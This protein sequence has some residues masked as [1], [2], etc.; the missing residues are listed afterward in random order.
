[1]VKKVKR[2]INVVI[3][4]GIVMFLVPACH[5][6][7]PYN[8]APDSVIPKPLELEKRDGSFH[9]ERKATLTYD[10]CFTD[11]GESIELFNEFLKCDYR[12]YSI[13]PVTGASGPA[14]IT[15]CF[16]GQCKDEGY[17]LEIGHDD[18]KIEASDGRGVF[19]A[20]QSLM[21]LI[22]PYCTSRHGSISIPC[23]KITDAPEFKWRGLHFDVA[24]HFFDKE[25]IFKLLDAMAIHKLNTF[26][27]HLTDDQGWRIEIK[28]Y[29]ALTATGSWRS[30]TLVGHGSETPW[31]YDG[32]SAGG[33][34]TQDDIREIVEYARRLKINIVPEIEMP[35]HAVAALRSYPEYSCNGKRVEEFDRWGV[36][37]DLFC[38]GN[39][40]TYR[41]LTDIL[42]E[43]IDLFPYE[44]IHI[45]GD[46]CPKVNWENCPLCQ[47]KIAD[48]NLKD[49]NELH[50]YFVKRI[51]SFLRDRGKKTV[52]WDEINEGDLPLS[53]AIMSWRGYS[54]G[55]NALEKGHD[56]IMTPH[57][58]VYFDYYQSG[59]N[60]PLA[61]GG[62]LDLQKVYSFKVVP[63]GTAPALRSRIIGAQANVWTEYIADEKQA[64][65]MIFPR[66]AAL[67]EAL[68][69]PE[70][71]LNYNDFSSRMNE[72]YARYDSKEINY[73]IQYPEG[74][75]GQN[76][77]LSDTFMTDLENDIACSSIHYTTGNSVPDENS[78]AFNTTLKI[79]PDSV[80]TLNAVTIMPSGR[81][82]SVITGIIRRTALKEAIEADSLTPGL[83]CKLYTGDFRSTFNLPSSPPDTAFI[84]RTIA[85]QGWMPAELFGLGYSGYIEVPSDGIYSFFTTSDDGI[86]LSIDNETVIDGNLR[87]HGITNQGCCAL[88]KGLHHL[89]V[90]YFQTSYRKSMEVYFSSSETE[91]RLIPAEILFN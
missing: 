66:L 10:S 39:E 11:I 68:W 53:A 8:Y 60:E 82:S 86:L 19:Y 4:T 48:N 25:F 85:L 26:H 12:G 46:E 38:A 3:V 65:Y 36:S 35:G 1:M 61:I 51:E 21:Q 47:K 67:A 52:I 45:G 50:I 33:Y 77:S 91:K 44:Y 87:H 79:V 89:Q 24:R 57:M 75:S 23:I 6:T 32:H 41:F 31:I 37:T 17:I 42:S 28:K 34:Y 13:R 69:T 62:L 49:E 30:Q 15:V 63:E 64:E 7:V 2:S 81:K 83:L 73:R 76:L 78:P 5:K 40:N 22:Y 43:V 74:L 80:C 88:K 84:A 70:S 90:R 56:V 71:D 58:Y 20:F 54:G 9:L 16:N 18:I 29:P 59:D 55:I 14:D 72:E 27:W